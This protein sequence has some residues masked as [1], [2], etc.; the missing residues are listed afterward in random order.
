MTTRGNAVVN[1]ILEKEVPTRMHKPT[2]QSSFEY[3]PSHDQHCGSQAL[4]TH[5]SAICD[6]R[7]HRELTTWIKAK[8][9]DQAFRHTPR[10]FEE[11]AQFE[12]D[13]TLLTFDA[14]L[15]SPSPSSSSSISSSSSTSAAATN[16]SAASAK[17]TSRRLHTAPN[18]IKS[19]SIDSLHSTDKPPFATG[20]QFS[21]YH[22]TSGIL[23]AVSV[24][25]TEATP[26]RRRSTKL[27]KRDIERGW[28]SIQ[29]E[30]RVPET[31]REDL[32][33]Q[34]QLERKRMIDEAKQR[35]KDKARLDRRSIT[36]LSFS[37]PSSSISSSSS[38]SSS[39]IKS[40]PLPLPSLSSSHA[41]SRSSSGSLSAGEVKREGRMKRLS[42]DLTSFFT[43]SS[44]DAL[45]GRKNS[46]SEGD[47]TWHADTPRVITGVRQR[48]VS[49]APSSPSTSTTS[50]PRD[51]ITGP[52][53]CSVIT[54]RRRKKS[55]NESSATRIAR[56]ESKEN[57]G[58]EAEA[59]ELET[60]ATREKK[61][62]ETG[63][64]EPKREKKDKE[65]KREKKGKEKTK[66]KTKHVVAE[67]S[68]ESS[69]RERKTEDKREIG[70]KEKRAKKE[71]APSIKETDATDKKHA[72]KKKTTSTSTTTTTSTK[73]KLNTSDE[74]PASQEHQLRSAKKPL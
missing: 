29:S 15:S 13:E 53:G 23:S 33:K 55:T 22:T 2:P 1:G 14:S 73:A 10:N 63:M 18:R 9:V 48:S 60:P 12:A 52:L 44:T 41:P 43:F 62:K 56:K 6:T 21:P 5:A 38:S 36:L 26:P 24:A 51:V 42:R 3:A 47:H 35:R 58:D 65:R 66:T 64:E 39:S 30:W 19:C 8:Y 32:I 71:R 54:P 7:A 49:A 17:P 40:A 16:N 20:S 31:D 34:Q 68:G 37:S 69:T 74:V 70:D 59:D 57:D 4:T 50:T 46:V 25:E 28:D 67:A 72:T 27:T 11:W 45:L 61:G